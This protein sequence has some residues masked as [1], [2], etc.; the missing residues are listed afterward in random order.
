VDEFEESDVPP[1]WVGNADL[2]LDMMKA[3]EDAGLKASANDLPCTE[4]RTS[5]SCFSSLSDEYTVFMSQTGDG[6]APMGV[7]ETQ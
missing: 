3:A 1:S 7:L 2:T 4:V 6:S 5:K